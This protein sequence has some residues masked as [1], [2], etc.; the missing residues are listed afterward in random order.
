MNINALYQEFLNSSGI[1]TDT[2]KI[3][4]NSIYFA[5]TGENFNGNNFVSEA[6]EKGAKLAVID[7]ANAQIKDRT[8]L[9]DD[10]LL[11]LQELAKTHRRQLKAQVIG[12]TGSN[13]K[14]TTKELINAV[15]SQ[16]FETAATQGNL[17]NHIGVPLTILSIPQ[18]AEIA[19]V[20]MGANHLGEIEVLSN[21]AQPDLGYITNFGK[22]H[23]EGFGS[24][25]GVVKGKTELYSFLKNNN[26]K[27]F[28]NA[29]DEKQMFNSEGMN[30]ITFGTADSDYPIQLVNAKNT[31]LVEFQDVQ[32]QSNLIGVYNFPNI[33]AAIAIGAYF[34]VPLHKIKQGIEGY[35]PANNRSQLIKKGSNVILLDAYNANPSS[36]LEAI[37]NVK[38]ME[39][40]KKV[41]FIG[42]MFELGTGAALEHQNIVN[43]LEQINFDQVHLIGKNFFQTQTTKS[44]IHKHQTFEEL[45][46]LL[47]SKIPTKSTILIKASRGMAL[48]RILDFLE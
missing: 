32:I 7:D 18:T 26:G 8:F 19:V 9:A 40:E 46:M 12:L 47:A 10:V 14:T 35:I 21:I 39:G 36:M 20:E 48:E 2:R 6:L 27:V 30:R 34:G 22:A 44:Y 42:D 1:S 5:L 4:T 45:E 16:H 31:L 25:E 33:S 41:L 15:L 17:N 3:G 28:V 24:L 37:K 13:G 11:T 43:V 23:L 38:Q 29:L